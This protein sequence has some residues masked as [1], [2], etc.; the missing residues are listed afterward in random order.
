MFVIDLKCGIRVIIVANAGAGVATGSWR[1]GRLWEAGVRMRHA[2]RQFHA[3]HL[4]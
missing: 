1:R 3:Q 2:R 4:M